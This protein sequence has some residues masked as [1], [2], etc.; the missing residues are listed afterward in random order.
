METWIWRTDTPSL[1]QNVGG[2]HHNII[3]GNTIHGDAH[4]HIHNEDSKAIASD[5][6]GGKTK[7]ENVQ[8]TTTS[9][10]DGNTVELE[11]DLEDMLVKLDLLSL[12][13]L[14]IEQELTMPFLAKLSKSPER[15]LEKDLER[16]GI[17]KIKQRFAIVD[18][19]KN[20]IENPKMF[21]LSSSG[22]S[23]D[24]VSNYCGVFTRAG[25]HNDRFYYKHL[26]TVGTQWDMFLYSSEH[27]G[28]W[29]VGPH[30]GD[31]DRHH[32]V[33]RTNTGNIPSSGSGWELSNGSINKRRRRTG[34]GRY[35]T[36]PDMI[37]NVSPLI[38]LSSITC[39]S[40]TITPVKELPSPDPNVFGTFTFNGDF[41]CG[42]QVFRHNSSGWFLI[43]CEKLNGKG[44][45]WVVRDTLTRERSY[46][47]CLSDDTAAV[48]TCPADQANS[49][50]WICKVKCETHTHK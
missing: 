17:T 43:V 22:K 21:L 41:M 9:T 37:I 34:G 32:L 29:F 20:W 24:Q 6:V 36:P 7:S 40:I 48:G 46:I 10:A 42:R 47:W 1:V 31:E 39:S 49:W 27:P 8:S 15:D 5:D 11:P 14:F 44:L 18:E 16:I 23:L 4:F 19:V 45:T 28:F 2:Q 12:K 35:Q 50:M 25:E 33:I 26:H 13:P 3:G 38:D 30:L